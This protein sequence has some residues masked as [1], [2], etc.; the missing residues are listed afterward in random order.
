MT[1]TTHPWL[2]SAALALSASVQ[3]SA[4]PAAAADLIDARGALRTFP[5]RDG[6]DGFYAVR[7]RRTAG[8]RRRSA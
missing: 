2:L 8:S 1:A 3:E 5:H 7:M 6:L 4:R